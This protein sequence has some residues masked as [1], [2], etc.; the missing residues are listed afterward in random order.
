M[1]LRLQRPD[2]LSARV[3]GGVRPL[4]YLRYNGGNEIAGGRPMPAANSQEGRF[5]DAMRASR[6]ACGRARSRG[7]ASSSCGLITHRAALAASPA[8]LFNP[9]LS[10]I[11][12][13]PMVDS[14]LLAW[15]DPG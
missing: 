15:E 6:G 10:E 5:G 7:A 11:L 1:S 13:R 4:V 9:R 12:P 2:R 3:G 8:V 14:E